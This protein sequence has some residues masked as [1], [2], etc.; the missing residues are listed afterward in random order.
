MRDFVGLGDLVGL[1]AAAAEEV[2]FAGLGDLAGLAR[3]GVDEFPFSDRRV[4]ELTARDP[5]L[6]HKKPDTDTLLLLAH[7]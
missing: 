2:G 5:H 4:L 1:A 6:P 3:V 7:I